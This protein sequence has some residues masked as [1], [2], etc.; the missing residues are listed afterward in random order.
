MTFLVSNASPSSPWGENVIDP[1]PKLETG[2]ANFNSVFGD[3]MGTIED[4]IIPDHQFT[5]AM[6]RN[7]LF[8]RP[9]NLNV[10]PNSLGNN[11]TGKSKIY[12]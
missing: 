1:V 9:L 2:W 12:F 5:L 10:D 6:E 4:E 3:S 11:S 8:T 7:I